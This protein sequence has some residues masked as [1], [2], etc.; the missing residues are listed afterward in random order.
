VK[1]VATSL[2][3]AG[4]MAAPAAAQSTGA[5]RPQP[6][7]T[8]A[9]RAAAPGPTERVF[10]SVNGG[11]Q[12]STTAF[13]DARSFELNA[14][15]AR[16]TAD[17]EVRSAPAIDAS[18]FVRL[19]RGLAAGVGVTRFSDDGDIAV[20]G[21]LPHPFFFNRDRAISG[22]AAGTR[23]ETAVHLQA[24]YVI[25]A[26][27]KLQIVVFGGPSFFTVKQSVVTDIGY[28]DRFPF[29]EATYTGA[30]VETESESKTGFTVGGDV[31]YYF[32]RHV[33]VGGFVRVARATVTF[34]L[35]EVDA[36]GLVAGGGVR[37]KF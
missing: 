1:T 33:G 27:R 23:E 9:A 2:L 24:A 5:A 37:L 36:G 12:A 22:T 18:G 4:V 35:G 29:D 19:W 3:L 17:Y 10:I 25:P 14:E 28:S 11:W 31:G 8:A 16:F 13:D 7:P 6:R 26:G 30:E 15:T 21:T 34:S 32:S 20:A